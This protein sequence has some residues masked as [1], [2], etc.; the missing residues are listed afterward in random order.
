MTESLAQ[1]QA[2]PFLASLNHPVLI[3]DRHFA[4]PWE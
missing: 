2:S 1:G 4:M 3:L